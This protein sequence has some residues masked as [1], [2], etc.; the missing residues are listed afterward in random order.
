MSLEY[1]I[2][3]T[4]VLI[5]IV[6]YALIALCFTTISILFY[7][8]DN[9]MLSKISRYLAVAALCGGIVHIVYLAKKY[10]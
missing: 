4:Y 9:I 10:W 8:T 3:K 1:L 2:K 5:H 7:I 6:F